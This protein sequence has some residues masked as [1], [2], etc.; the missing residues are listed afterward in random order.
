[1]IPKTQYQKYLFL[2]KTYSTFRCICSTNKLYRSD[3]N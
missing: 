3:F 2:L 1:L